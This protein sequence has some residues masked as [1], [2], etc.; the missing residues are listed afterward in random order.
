MNDE[1]ILALYAAR[2]DQAV[3]ETDRKY[4]RYCF[5][6]AQDILHDPQDSEEIVS[7]TYLHTWNAIPP[8]K[9]DIFR[10]F[11]AKVTRN[12]AFT[13]WRSYRAQKRGGGQMELVLEELG[14]C[15]SSPDAVDDNWNR[16]E[17]EHA[18][19]KFLKQLSSRDQNL[20]VRRYFF[21]ESTDAIAMRYGMKPGTVLRALSRSREKLRNYLIQEGFAL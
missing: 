5:C 11:L 9:P 19:R 12:L 2:D 3:V 14:E 15:V 8:Q 16:R 17:L 6:L 4:G 21:V 13:R 20:F 7:D 10:V 1:Q 18:I